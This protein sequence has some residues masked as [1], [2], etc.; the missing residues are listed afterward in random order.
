MRSTWVGLAWSRGR[1]QG[2]VADFV[3][4][5]MYKFIIKQVKVMNSNEG[6]Y[7]EEYMEV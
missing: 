2:N 6:V 3:S 1:K 4:S 5:T 7:S